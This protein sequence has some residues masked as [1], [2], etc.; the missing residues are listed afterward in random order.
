MSAE[1]TTNFV[2]VLPGN[3]I[4][5]RALERELREAEQQIEDLLSRRVRIL[6]EAIAGFTVGNGPHLE[7]IAEARRL[8][9]EAETNYRLVVLEL[10][11]ARAMTLNP[12]SY[13]GGNVKITVTPCHIPFEEAPKKRRSKPS[14]PRGVRS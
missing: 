4:L 9:T 11:K 8:L 6:S 5:V 2:H 12:P 14:G 3:P 10:E 1:T 13:V 7:R